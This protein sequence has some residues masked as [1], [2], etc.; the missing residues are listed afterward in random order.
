MAE[1][2]LKTKIKVRR[3]TSVEWN[4]ANPILALGEIGYDSTNNSIKIGNGTSKWAELPYSTAGTAAKLQTYKQGSTTETYGNNYP[5]YAQWEDN[6]KVKLKC[7]NYTVKTDYATA[8]GNSSK[9]NGHTVNSDVPSD[10]VFTDTKYT[11]KIEK[12]DN[13]AYSVR[14]EG[15]DKSV[16][17]FHILPG[18][19]ITMNLDDNSNFT[20]NGPAL[21]TSLKNPNSISLQTVNGT[22]GNVSTITYDGSEAKSFTISPSTL[23]AA[24]SNH[25]HSGFIIKLNGGSTEGTNMFTYNG[26]AAKTINITPSK[27]G[28]AASSHSHNA[29]SPSSTSY[30]D[31]DAI[32]STSVANSLV[33]VNITSSWKNAPSGVTGKGLLLIQS[34]APGPWSQILTMENGYIY[35][36]Q[37]INSKWTDWQLLSDFMEELPDICDLNNYY[38]TEL[39]PTRKFH[40]VFGSLIDPNKSISNT[41]AGTLSLAESFVADITLTIT[42]IKNYAGGV[43]ISTK[44]DLWINHNHC[45][46][47][48]YKD[49]NRDIIW[50]RWKSLNLPQEDNIVYSS[51]INSDT[52]HVTIKKIN[53][54][55]ILS[56]KYITAKSMYRTEDNWVFTI[57]ADYRPNRDLEFA[58]VTQPTDS[59]T[60]FG[61]F[62]RLTV[63]SDGKCYASER[64]SG[65]Y[66]GPEGWLSTE[67]MWTID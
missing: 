7:D 10:A 55:V 38:Y 15:R 63:K 23:G 33:T 66:W 31:F 57:P 20:I 4:K 43:V 14:I 27:I 65:E 36:R 12:T 17:G 13:N 52:S 41:P 54:L 47:I 56:G 46:R 3:G 21:P 11:M 34:V 62:Y 9:V 50:G 24:L 22:N 44:Q 59:D 61:T 2:T 28:A 26:S 8:S 53:N 39:G 37:Y 58:C 51:Y 30:T 32:F 35:K 64:S 6:S 29:L 49:P 48:G 19:N 60:R 45:E 40:G 25:T 67:V 42:S 16:T 1:S 18:T 5:V